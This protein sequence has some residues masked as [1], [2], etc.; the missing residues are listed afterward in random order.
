VRAPCI[1]SDSFRSDPC[2]GDFRIFFGA[3]RPNPPA[4]KHSGVKA[5]EKKYFM[6]KKIG[7][8]VSKCCIDDKIEIGFLI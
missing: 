6:A 4:K 1:L 8:F 5:M 3:L 7:D 2:G